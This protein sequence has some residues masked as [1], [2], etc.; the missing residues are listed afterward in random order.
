MNEYKYVTNEIFPHGLGTR[1]SLLL[2]AIT[3]SI[4]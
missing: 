2:N 1:I 3:Y 4:I